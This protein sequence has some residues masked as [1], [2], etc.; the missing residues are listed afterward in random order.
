M[1]N[2]LNKWKNYFSEHYK[3]HFDSAEV[4]RA[5]NFLHGQFKIVNKVAPLSKDDK[6][7]EIGCAL[8]A[9]V[10][11]MKEAGVSNISAIELDESAA[12]YVRK[13][14]GIEVH[15]KTINKLPDLKRFTKIYAFEVLEHL[16][17]PIRDIEKIHDL[18]EPN[19]YFI[20][21]TPYPFS[22]S[23]LSDRT[24]LFVLHPENWRRLFSNAGF[25]VCLVRPATGLPLFYRFSKALSVYFNFYV[26]VLPLVST[27]L[28]VIQ[29]KS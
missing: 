5:K 27:T 1:S 8:G 29:K 22:R 11:E 9:F 15:T 26:P 19:G 12:E 7:L 20:G 13:T 16:E 17:D 23:I 24:H 6:V 25:N 14:Q 10:V 18:L 2:E 3:S 28:F 4:E 21:S